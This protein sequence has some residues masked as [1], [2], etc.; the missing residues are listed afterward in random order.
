MEFADVSRDVEAVRQVHAFLLPH[1]GEVELEPLSHY[2]EEATSPGDVETII[3]AS[4]D[5]EGVVTAAIGSLIGLSGGRVLGAVG[6]A[7][8]HGRLRGQ[9]AGRRLNAALEERLTH[10]A[11]AQGLVLEA[12]VL[13]S[14]AAA[15]FFWDR[16]GYR[17]PVGCRY[18]QPPLRYT[19]DGAPDLPMI[20]LLFLLRHPEHTERIPGPLVREYVEATLMVWYFEELAQTLSGAALKRAE[21][22]LMAAVI[23]PAV[24][25]LVD[26]QVALRP[27]GP[28][29]DAEVAAWLSVTP[30]GT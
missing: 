24:E 9:G 22:W 30:D 5:G 15:R 17:W 25:S 1:F 26:A 6:H 18:S 7:L 27:P 20:P 3:V 4:R 10:Y 16:V 13:E 29:A 11:A 23:T 12:F 21:D 19:E 2:L 14:E 28:M 8:V